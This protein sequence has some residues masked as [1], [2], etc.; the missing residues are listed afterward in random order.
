M[1]MSICMSIHVPYICL[2]KVIRREAPLGAPDSPWQRPTCAVH[3][4]RMH[5]SAS[6]DQAGSMAAL[7]QVHLIQ[8]NH[9]DVGF[10]DP[11]PGTADVEGYGLI[12]RVLNFYF[13]KH[14][15]AA[16]NTSRV[17]R[18]RAGGERLVLADMLAL[19]GCSPSELRTN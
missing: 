10:S 4:A 12:S 17:L 18:A 6:S 3:A 7:R 19:G 8:S 13:E 14:L 5:C 15:P 9:L 2:Y 16:A 11:L 1:R